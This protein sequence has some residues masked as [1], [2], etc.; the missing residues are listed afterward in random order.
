MKRR[1]GS[2]WTPQDSWK[3][4][5]AALYHGIKSIFLDEVQGSLHDALLHGRGHLHHSRGL[6]SVN[7]ANRAIPYTTS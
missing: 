2:W 7:V 4:M 1:D 3:H 6:K 5:D